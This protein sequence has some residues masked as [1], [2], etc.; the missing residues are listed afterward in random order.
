MVAIKQGGTAGAAID[1]I[2]ETIASMID[3]CNFL[4]AYWYPRGRNG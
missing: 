3:R 2:N 1:G 4:V